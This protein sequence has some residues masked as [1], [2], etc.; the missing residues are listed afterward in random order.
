MLGSIIHEAADAGDVEALRQLLEERARALEQ[1][2]QQ[3]IEVG[4][5]SS[6]D[7]G[8]PPVPANTICCYSEAM[9]ADIFQHSIVGARRVAVHGLECAVAI[10]L[11]G[12]C[13]LSV[14]PG[15]LAMLICQCSALSWTIT[16]RARTRASAHHC[17]LPSSGVSLNGL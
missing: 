6:Y 3:L 8:W 9:T 15:R 11:T 7:I 13:W 1:R 5:A 4:S 14:V 10:F 16:Y 17:T 2:R 12:L